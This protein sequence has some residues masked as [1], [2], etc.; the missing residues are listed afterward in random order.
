MTKTPLKKAAV[1]FLSIA[2][3]FLGSAQYADAAT[4]SPYS[5]SL[6]ST[7]TDIDTYF[8]LQ[9]F[10]TRLGTLSKVT[11]SLSSGAST[12]IT[13]QNT[14]PSGSSGTVYTSLK[15]TLS[16]PD[17]LLSQKLTLIV[18]DTDGLNYSLLAGGS[19]TTGEATATGNN[20]VDYTSGLILSEFSTVGV[21]NIRL[22]LATLT[23]TTLTNTGGNTSAS[24]ETY[25][26]AT[27][28]VTYTYVAAPPAVPE[29]STWAMLVGGVGLLAF[30]QR[31]RRRAV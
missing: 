10:D 11:L 15:L 27:A 3:T 30:G 26:D 19:M 5:A 22:G 18:P 8:L 14:S 9:K 24:Q 23:K 13:L 4:T 7:K 17:A 31:M 28:T 29:P 25:A 2:L 1:S 6:S 20:T 12:T 21:G 16:D